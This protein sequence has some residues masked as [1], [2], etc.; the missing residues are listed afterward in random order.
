MVVAHDLLEYLHMN[1]LTGNLFAFFCST[2]CCFVKNKVK[3]GE[4][5]Q[6][7]LL[8]K[9]PKLEDIFITVA[10]V[11]HHYERLAVLKMVCAIIRPRYISDWI[12]KNMAIEMSLIY[13]LTEV[14]WSSRDWGSDE[15]SGTWNEAK[16]AVVTIQIDTELFQKLLFHGVVENIKQKDNFS[17]WR[18]PYIT[19]NIKRMLTNTF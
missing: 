15:C 18:K 17:W 3:N 19:H 10:I 1:D 12:C 8:A 9:M 5:S 7:E 2:W 6:K 11:C 4:T 14:N 16:Y 13:L